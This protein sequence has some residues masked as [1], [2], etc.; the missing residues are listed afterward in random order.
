MSQTVTDGMSALEDGMSAVPT[1][2]P[3][4]PIAEAP[5]AP[6]A[7][8]RFNTRGRSLR[9]FA[10]RGMLINTGFNVALNLLGL[11]RGFAL[12]AFL[13]RSDYGVWGVLAVT[14]GILARLKVVGVGEKYIQQDEDDQQLAFQHAFTMEALVTAI[15]TVPLILA[16]P[17]VA[18]IYGHWSLVA[19]GAA[20]LLAL[21]A[22]VLQVPLWVYYRKMEFT[23]AGFMQAIDPV[24]GI[25]VTLALAIAGAG[26]W[27]LVV[28]VLSGAWA[29]ALFAIF[30]SPYPLRFK[31][32]KG[33]M[34]LYRAYSWPLLVASASSIVLANS[35]A[36]ATN[37]RLGL[38]G[39]GAIALAS[40]ITLFTSRVDD[41]VSG[42]LFPAICAAKDRL[43][44]LK[45][46]FVKVNRLALM[47]AMP[48]GV[49]LA[50][51]CADLVHF[52][53]G[54]RWQPAV[55]ILQITGVVA[56]I[57]HIGFNWD[58]YFRAEGDTKPIAVAAVGTAA[59]FVAVGV[60]L[61][62]SFGLR[63]L[64]F[65]IGFQALVAL[66][67]RA[68][69]LK[70]LFDG[71]AFM[72]HAI[73]AILPTVPAA[74]VT[75]LMRLAERGP[76]TLPIA[77][78]ELASYLLITAGATWLLEERLLSEAVGYLLERRSTAA[79]ST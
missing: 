26:Y 70:R 47:W 43:D 49:A 1:G 18:V 19:P 73:R 21:P 5:V 29:T 59:S 13:T 78:G 39:V 31:Y 35:A 2:E 63:G 58:D 51:F 48:F 50:L 6:P 41:I 62:L 17:L 56:A 9:G 52:V 76:R 37:A 57:G 33:V 8:R 71:F 20:M 46:S 53:L 10:A 61:T 22:G 14:L 67:F 11:I 3:Q 75:L 25:V 24:V 34:K 68:F 55:Q 74:G 77:L 23:R 65:G 79:V 36:L 7:R 38:A 45:E 32:Q 30:K 69:Y 64:A 12:A 44:L 27:S 40:N 4:R 42:T 72:R 28:G 60:P 54:A 15:V 66:G 16:L